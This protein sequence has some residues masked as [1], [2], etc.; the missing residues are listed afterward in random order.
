MPWEQ[1]TF[2]C[3]LCMCVYPSFTA[4]EAPLVSLFTLASVLLMK[5][6]DWSSSVPKSPGSPWLQL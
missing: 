3:T 4:W 5:A 2:V 1:L 6:A